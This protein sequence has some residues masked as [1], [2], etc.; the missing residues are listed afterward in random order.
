V[1]NIGK[2][3]ADFNNTGHNL[4]GQTFSQGGFRYSD[5]NAVSG[6]ALSAPITDPSVAWVSGDILPATLT[7]NVTNLHPN[8]TYYMQSYLDATTSAILYSP[9]VPFTTLPEVTAA[10]AVINGT[11]PGNTKINATFYSNTS[12]QTRAID[13]ADIYWGETGVWNVSAL[14]TLDLSVGAT[15]LNTL[16]TV[17]SNA[18]ATHVPLVK[19]TSFTDAG[20][21]DYLGVTGLTAGKTYNI[22][23]VITNED[24]GKDFKL[25]TYKAGLPI[26]VT[27]PVKLVFAAFESDEGVITSPEY[28]ITSYN[29]KGAAAG[30]TDNTT[31]IDVT[32]STFKDIDTAHAGGAGTTWNTSQGLTLDSLTSPPTV[33]YHFNLKL[34]GYDSTYTT[35]TTDTGWLHTG[36]TSSA[37]LKTLEPPGSSMTSSNTW[38]FTLEGAYKG[39]FNLI[40]MPEYS[41]VFKFAVNDS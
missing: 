25:I 10:A 31:K 38:Y 29:S 24:G 4:Y 17:T 8:T 19:G 5:S 36:Y 6:W 32:L 27:A 21:A 12:P 23:I 3:T 35:K 22:V 30:W 40:R 28:Y 14:A 7:K 34:Q 41:A 20:I 16:N 18:A 39:D 33:N 26:S 37:V 13:Y 1:S 9:V 11:D 2:T 15:A